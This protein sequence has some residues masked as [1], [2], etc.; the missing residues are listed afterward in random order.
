MSYQIT[1]TLG[2]WSC[3]GHGRAEKHTIKSNIPKPELET[4]YAEGVK[5]TGVDLTKSI[6]REFDNNLFP[7]VAID[8]LSLFGFD[9][10]DF[11]MF[12]DYDGVEHWYI[13]SEGFVD[14]WLFIAKIGNPDLEYIL[15]KTDN[16]NIGGYG[17]F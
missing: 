2:D 4:A 1:L 8:K 5:R 9:P 10:N 3:D 14:L 15:Y 16:I 6:A 12:D 17:L 13:D 11:L 7:Q